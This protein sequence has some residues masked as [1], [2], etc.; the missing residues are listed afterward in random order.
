MCDYKTVKQFAKE[1]D[2]NLN[3]RVMDMHERNRGAQ[4][5]ILSYM[6][7][8]FKYP[9]DFKTL[10]YAS[11]L[12]Q[13]EAVKTGIE[14]FRRN[15]GY[16]M[17]SIYWQ[18]NDC[19][20]VASWSSIDYF[21]RYKALH[22][23]AKKFYQP[24]ML[25][26]F[27]ET[28]KIDIAVANE[29]LNDFK[30]YIKYGVSKNDFSVVYEGG[31]SV[32][33]PALSSLDIESLSNKEFTN[34]RDTY[35][36]CELYDEND[37]LLARNTELGTKPKHF[38]FLK[39]NIKID[40]KECKDGVEILISSDVFAKNNEISFKNYDIVLSDN[41]FD[42][43]DNKEYRVVAKTSL[44]ANEILNNIKIVS[45]YDISK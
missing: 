32:F 38:E 4:G 22:Y 7:N 17:G 5:K 2:M 20:P 39:P 16:T 3:S 40:A 11:Q 21:G 30:G 41:Y 9:S 42:L 14:H 1:E 28:D 19:W 34:L 25:G 12:L 24:I 45:V 27:N 10:I 6:C 29:S 26:L 23:F 13:A 33:V 36:W 18:L 37:T 8:Y 15:R 35:F 31:K 43:T 44:S